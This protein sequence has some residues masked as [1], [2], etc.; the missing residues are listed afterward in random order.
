[1]SKSG[2]AGREHG[3]TRDK[4]CSC[5]PANP[6][7][8][9]VIDTNGACD[10]SYDAYVYSYPKDPAAKWEQ[11]FRFA[12]VASAYGAQHLGHE[13]RLPVPADII[14]AAYGDPLQV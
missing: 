13:A 2:L 7:D 9:R 5:Q 8:D 4:L 10:L 11:D 12:R 6:D 3:I 14:A 1:M